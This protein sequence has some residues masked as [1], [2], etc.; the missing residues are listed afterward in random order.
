MTAEEMQRGEFELV[1]LDEIPLWLKSADEII[2]RLINGEAV[3]AP[4][5]DVWYGALKH[6]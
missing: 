5:S 3:L 1:P 6:E 4:G 2:E